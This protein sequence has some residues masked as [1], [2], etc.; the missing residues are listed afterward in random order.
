MQTKFKTL[1]AAVAL[2]ASA[3]ALAAPTNF[4]FN[5][6][7]A[8]DDNVQLFNFSVGAL[9]DVTLVSYGYAG[10]TQANG[11]VVA[12]GGFDTI[13]ALFNASTGTLIS[14][15][16]DAPGATCGPVTVAVDPTTSVRYDTCLNAQLAAGAYTVAVM[17]YDNFANGPD[18][19]AGFMRTGT[20]NFTQTFS[21]CAN[22]TQFCDATGDART[23]A[24]A[25]DI[26]G[27][28]RATQNNVP[29]P[30][31]LALAGLALLGLGLRRRARAA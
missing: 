16:D 28:D 26:L 5:G 9:S 27:V 3:S 14:Q 7:F 17:Q 15:N 23:N 20:G 24:W 10:G 4:S 22:V 6:T 31:S 1:M 29:E 21:G 11:N 13:L 30:G 18:L 8:Q 19:A 25:F 12:R 2:A